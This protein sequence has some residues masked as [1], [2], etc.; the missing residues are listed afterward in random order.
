MEDAEP[1]RPGA[2]V[3]YAGGRPFR[4][5]LIWYALASLGITA[6]WGGVLGVLLP[7]Q[8]Q[9]MEFARWFTGHDSGV[10]LTALTNLNNA[11]H[12]GNVVPTAA[13]R[14]LLSV[15]DDF[16]AARARSL[17]LVTAFGIGLTMIA[18]PVVGVLSDR[19]RSR[20]GRRAPWMLVGAIAGSGFLA[21]V[22]FAP[23][24]LLLTV[25]WSFTQ[26]TINSIQGPL[27][28]TT[29]D[30]VPA[31]KIGTASALGGL[32]MMLG[33]VG[34]GI[35][36]G[37]LFGSLGFNIYYIF[38]VILLAAVIGFVVRLPDRPSLELPVAPE[39][40]WGEF[41]RGFLVPMRDTDFRWVWTARVSLTFG[42][43][44]STAFSFYMLQSY[45]HPAMSAT[46]ATKFVPLLAVAGLPGTVLALAF[47]GRLSDRIGRRK[48]FVVAASLLMALSMTVPLLWPTVPALFVQVVLAGVAFGVYLP[49]DQALFI[50]VLPDRDKAG[51][52]LGVADTGSNLGQALGPVLAGQAVAL[53]GGYRMIWVLAFVLVFAA[54]LAIL[55]VKRSR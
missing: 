4:T 38:V 52:D 44:I 47:V 25:V 17:S 13:Q 7:N 22:R 46:D 10:D 42:Y 2:S 51:R 50:D 41:L 37:V 23:S 36:A 30:R 54:A 40:H 26:F 3:T 11:V 43:T 45:V 20:W 16:D 12:D 53:T 24:A 15:Y 9:Q 28:A 32:G 21:I 48:P 19:T 39:Q 1:V 5:Y 8:V 49:V 31:H 33:G 14:H 18:Q 34:G 55:P 6:V 29:A 27:K 35:L